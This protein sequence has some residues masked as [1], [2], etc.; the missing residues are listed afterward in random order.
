MLGNTRDVPLS[1]YKDVIVTFIA[2]N[3]RQTVIERIHWTR[4]G[5]TTGTM[6]RVTKLIHVYVQCFLVS[7]KI[8][9]GYT[10]INIYQS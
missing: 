1:F 7:S 3:R 5:S 10:T 4:H 6:D 9:W 8:Y 2:R